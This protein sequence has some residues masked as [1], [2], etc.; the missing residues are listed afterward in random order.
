MSRFNFIVYCIVLYR[1][2]NCN[3]SNVLIVFFPVVIQVLKDWHWISR[4]GLSLN[5]GIKTFLM[6]SGFSAI[7]LVGLG[8]FA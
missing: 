5:K 3:V 8:G 7:V 6:F 2:K 1:D 4:T